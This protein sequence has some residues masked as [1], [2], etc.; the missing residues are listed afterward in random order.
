MQQPVKT[1]IIIGN[2][3]IDWQNA[4]K[5]LHKLRIRCLEKLFNTSEIHYINNHNLPILAFWH[6]WS[7]KESAYKAWQRLENTKSVFNPNAFCC[8]DIQ[9]HLVRVVNG[10]FSCQVVTVFNSAYIYSQCQ[11]KSLNFKILK[12]NFEF[13]NFKN[14]REKQG[15]HIQKTSN[16]IPNLFDPKH[17]IQKPLSIS[18]DNEFTAVC[19]V[20]S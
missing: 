19:W 3:I 16:N 2:D 20:D 13:L 7:V 18:H 15:W 11:S 6:L 4:K 17:N 5:Q 14:Q 8:Q 10:G 1:Q 12:S 9:S